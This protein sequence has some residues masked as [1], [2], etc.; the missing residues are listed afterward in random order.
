MIEIFLQKINN[1]GKKQDWTAIVDDNIVTFK[2]G[3]NGGKIQIKEV[4]FT[5]GKNIGR[6][7]E[8]T[9]AEQCLKDTIA[10]AVK[11]IESGYEVIKGAEFIETNVNENTT[12]ADVTIPKPML[13]HPYQDHVKKFEKEFSIYVQP[14]LDGNRCLVNV[15]TGKLYS[16]SRKEIISVPHIG[17]EVMDLFS[18]TDI[19]WLDG[20]LYSHTISFNEIQSFVRKKKDID[21]EASKII[22][23]NVFD[24][25]SSDTFI[26]RSEKLEAIFNKIEPKHLSLVKTYKIRLQDLQD[27]HDK[28]VKDGYEGIMIRK[29][30]SP[31]EQKRSL[32]LFKYKNFFDD[33]YEVVGFVGQ[34]KN[35]HLLATVT[36][37]DK[38]G[39]EFPATPSMTQEMKAYIFANQEEFIGKMATVRYQELF[40]DTQVPRFGVLKSFRDKEDMGE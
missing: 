31:Y 18:G 1:N 17:K 24:Y 32:G 19:E 39:V 13:A 30:N 11:K 9:P 16:R 36:V 23:F 38:R 26:D 37:K 34:E 40:E 22:S 27:A 2:W 33:E 20:E 15:K 6:A 5:K 7:N 29:P 3:Q 25:I 35:P 4:E 8:T 28:F 10:K 12:M 14:K 21:Y